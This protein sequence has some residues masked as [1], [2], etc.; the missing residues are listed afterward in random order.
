ME[1]SSSREKKE[2]KTWSTLTLRLR[3]EEKEILRELAEREDLPLTFFA[4]RLLRE[5]IKRAQP[6][7]A[8]KSAPQK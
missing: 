4:K 1:Q 7:F 6:D 8:E 5:E 3:V 2:N